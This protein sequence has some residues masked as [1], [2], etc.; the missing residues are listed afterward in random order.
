MTRRASSR[1]L[2]H[3]LRAAH[4]GLLDLSATGASDVVFVREHR[5]PPSSFFDPLEEQA[6]ELGFVV[7][8]APLP[9]EAGFDSL[10]AI[11]KSFALHARSAKSDDKGLFELLDA[12]GKERGRG[13]V[14]AFDEA[15]E[16]VGLS[17]DLAR[18]CRAYLAAKRNDKLESRRL[19]AF[20][21]GKEPSG[22]IAATPLS[23]RTAKRALADLSRL[24]RALGYEGTV[25]IARRS[26]QQT[27]LPP[28]QRESAYTVLRELADNADGPRG[29]IAT[30]LYVSGADEL[31]Q[32]ARSIEENTPLSMRIL[33][34]E[35]A[36]PRAG[37]L[38]HATVVH[39][40]PAYGE[41][42]T[43]DD[44]DIE[45]RAPEAVG[46]R[47]AKALASVV[48][49]SMGLPPLTQL[50][51]LTVGYEK[52]DE[53]LDR[54][55]EHASNEGSVFSLL[56]GE[57]GSGKTHLL[58]H[59]TARALTDKRPVLRL[60]VERLDTDLGN[61]QRHLRRL[62]EGALLPGAG[63][64]SPLDRL[65]AWMRSD[66]ATAR[67]RAT[68]EAVGE[69]SDGASGASR[70]ALAALDEGPSA[71]EALLA[72]HDLATK[73][74]SAN[75]RQDAYGRL[76]LW[77]ELFER[78]DGC[79]GPVV[80]IDEAENLYR[81]GTSRPERRTAL[82]SLGF[83]CGGSLPRTCVI[84]AVTPETLALLREEAEEML[85]DITEQRTLLPCEDVTMLRRRLL[86]A[87]PM[88]VAKLG[89]PELAELADKI[90]AV[91]GAA[92]GTVRDKE[93]DAWVERSV[94]RV[95]QPRE[96]VRAAITRLEAQWWIS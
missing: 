5:A 76:L 39:L 54:L 4:Q 8:T 23:D 64:P 47:R 59:V 84:F 79:A 6:L 85:D 73:A 10:A 95:D 22:E 46:P 77:I 69:S 56:A 74:G 38:P 18:L 7:A 94:K 61:P 48:R 57:Y 3:L 67:L 16:A 91:H 81:G 71:L 96:L 52:V 27:D 51:D 31:F 45:P 36:G 86:K 14:D 20:L 26:G 29:M 75:Y 21:D 32:G 33:E 9:A 68:I 53:T 65:A 87:R 82:R 24:V 93:W 15:A 41:D 30:R 42:G 50:D 58:M 12:F 17:G 13:A 35:L 66:A 2:E 44:A 83:Y 37:L 28:A 49:A 43:P 25:L 62:I 55:F 70:K 1:H 90:R 60:S 40:E 89:R 11:V 72:G 88:Q 78:L 92:R 19:R 63:T 34:G 80:I